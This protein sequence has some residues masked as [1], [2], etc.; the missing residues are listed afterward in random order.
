MWVAI[1]LL[2][3][4]SFLVMMY[5]VIV[6]H[7]FFVFFGIIYSYSFF[8]KRSLFC[9]FFLFEIKSSKNNRFLFLFSPGQADRLTKYQC[10]RLGRWFTLFFYVVNII[11]L[12]FFYLWKSL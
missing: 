4:F 8:R 7:I 11:L 12:Y 3:F 10:D 9:V 2:S 1:T 6:D 5:N